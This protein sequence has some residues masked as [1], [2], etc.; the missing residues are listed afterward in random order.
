MLFLAG[1]GNPSHAATNADGVRTFGIPLDQLKANGYAEVIAEIHRAKERIGFEH[2]IW[3][4]DEGKFRIESNMTST[5]SPRS[6]RWNYVVCDGRSVYMALVDPQAPEKTRWQTLPPGDEWTDQLATS[7]VSSRRLR[8][9]RLVG[10]EEVMGLRSEHWRGIDV[11]G[12]N[13]PINDVWVSTDPRFPLV[14]RNVWKGRDSGGEWR[15]TKLDLKPRVPDYIFTAQVDPKPGFLRV[16]LSPFKPPSVIILWHAL[17]LLAYAGAVVSFTAGRGSFKLS[18]RIVLGAI[19][20]TAFSLLAI[21]APRL[22]AYVGAFSGT[23]LWLVRAL[24]SVAFMFLMLRAFGRPGG[25]VLFRGTTIFSVLLMLG[26]GYLGAKIA[27]MSYLP[28]YHDLGLHADLRPVLLAAPLANI[29]LDMAC[30]TAVE[31]LV[32]RGHLFSALHR[33]LKSIWAV[34]LVQVII[35]GV[36]HIPGR[37]AAGDSLPH[38]AFGIPSLIV[39]GILFGVLRSRYRNLGVPWLAHFAY[40]ASLF[41]VSFLYMDHLTRFGVGH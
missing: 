41:Y 37:L 39:F 35:F 34:I 40:N 30:V 20:V 24:L 21:W 33:S 36:Y 14:L 26:A 32:F 4:T 38:L 5:K 2:R 31:E 10:R 22:D 9:A 23:P 8:D 1:I 3:F 27:Q 11:K 17:I 15:I 19:A 6:D 25:V 16:L 13:K 7:L 28:L 29:L 12:K 18:R